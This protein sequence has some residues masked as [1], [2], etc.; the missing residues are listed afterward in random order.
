MKSRMHDIKQGLKTQ[1]QDIPDTGTKA[2]VH[3][4]HGEVQ[5]LFPGEGLKFHFLLILTMM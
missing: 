2:E 1:I 5:R 4:E 3:A